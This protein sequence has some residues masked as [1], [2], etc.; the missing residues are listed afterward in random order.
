MATCRARS[1]AVARSGVLAV[2]PGARVE[3]A[4]TAQPTVHHLLP[5]GLDEA[6]RGE[7]VQRGIQSARPELDPASGDAV[8]IGHDPVA[9]LRAIRQRREE[10]E[11]RFLQRAVVH[12]DVIYRRSEYRKPFTPPGCATSMIT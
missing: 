2:P 4:P 1:R 8:D 9:V 10:E 12:T 6:L 5:V 3:A 7:P 11:R